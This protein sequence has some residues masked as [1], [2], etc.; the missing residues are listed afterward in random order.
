MQTIVQ[1]THSIPFKGFEFTFPQSYILSNLKLHYD[2][3]QK[4]QIHLFEDDK[5]QYGIFVKHPLYKI[6]IAYKDGYYFVLYTS[7]TSNTLYTSNIYKKA[8][9]LSFLKYIVNEIL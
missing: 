9:M 4:D 7:N 8:E 2:S 3:I 5:L 1:S 6:K